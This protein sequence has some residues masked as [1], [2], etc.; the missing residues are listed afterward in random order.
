[1]SKEN[2]RSENTWDDQDESEM[3]R[4][5]REAYL[6][7]ISQNRPRPRSSNIPQ[8]KAPETPGRPGSRAR[9]GGGRIYEEGDER[10]SRPRPIKQSREEVYARLRQRPRRPV[11]ARDQEETP[12]RPPAQT[13][14]QGRSVARRVPAEEYP[15]AQEP[16][17]PM[18][19]AS[20][21]A[22]SGGAPRPGRR[23]TGYE[24][25]DEYDVEVIER[26]RGARRPPTRRRRGGRVFSTLLTGCLGGILTLIVVAAVVVFLL[27]HN[28]PLGQNLGVGKTTYTQT[29][30]QTLALG[31]A[32]QVIVKSMA[33]N[34]TV[35]IDQG[36]SSATL[37]SI[38]KVLASS[39]SDANS[40][41]RALTL[42]PRQ[43]GKGADPACTA[44]SCL[45]ITASVPTT[46]D[47]SLLGGGN[48]NTLDLTLTLPASFNS[49]DPLAPYTINVN[50]QG[51]DIAVS[52]FN[53]ILNLTGRAGNIS[54][55]HALIYAGTCIQTNQG[56]VVVGQGSFFDLNQSSNQVP[57]SATTSTGAH[58]WF[59][60]KSGVGNVDITLPAN[61]AD[62]LLD[63][64]T[65][66]GKISD[67]FG[68]NIPTA[69]DG[70]ATYH[71]P[72]LP[73]TNPTASLYVS[74]STGDIMI[75][76][77]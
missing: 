7:S 20:R 37:S 39:Q 48:G 75:R 70:S 30:R 44:D 24:E 63:A 53:G 3:P 36:A 10:S 5:F 17:P 35:T 6:D 16:A 25:Y 67:D 29:A 23:E 26:G 61:S 21:P 28:T 18:R 45:L 66:N 55:S 42:T 71:G 49:P 11:Y 47:G 40:Q 22:A 8:A 46:S 77:P 56:N 1:M 33:G 43:I 65:N 9:P 73:N 60:I 4:G 38:R 52:G 59:N 50:A 62:V 14:D 32:T 19:R 57:C 34:V 15:E 76:K 68:R 51:G 12:S 2:D 27:L 58:P 69:S 72:L 54:V 13:R 31:S 74:T 64:N 41:F